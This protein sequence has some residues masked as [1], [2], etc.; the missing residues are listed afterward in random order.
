MKPQKLLVIAAL[1]FSG[2]CIGLR[3][4][5]RSIAGDDVP[6]LAIVAVVFA[7]AGMMGY[8]GRK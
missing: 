2:A 5:M 7:F 3:M 1:F 4:L 6:T 8:V